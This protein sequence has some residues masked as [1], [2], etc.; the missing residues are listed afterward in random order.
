M[1]NIFVIVHLKVVWHNN[2]T[3]PNVEIQF[4]SRGWEAK[5]VKFVRTGSA[6]HL[7]KQLPAY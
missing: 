7:A 2:W 1:P 4:E 5:K 6:R 3:A